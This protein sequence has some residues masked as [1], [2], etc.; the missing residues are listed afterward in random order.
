MEFCL[1]PKCPTK[2]VEG[3]AGREAKA[4][5]KGEVEKECPSCK[6][7]KLVLRGSIYGKFYGCS[8]YPKCKHTEKLADG[9]LKEDFEKKD[10]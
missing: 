8:N 4:V 2:H 6:E 5:A 7:W 3:E 1:N 10:K 9:P